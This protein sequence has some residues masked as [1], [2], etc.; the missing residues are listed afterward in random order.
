MSWHVHCL[1]RPAT[2]AELREIVSR[3][4]H[5]LEIFGWTDAVLILNREL[6]QQ[7][8]ISASHV[9]FHPLER[10]SGAVGQPEENYVVYRVRMY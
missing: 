7:Q 4:T 9:L 1:E 6:T 5:A 2:D 10:F 8:E 3:V